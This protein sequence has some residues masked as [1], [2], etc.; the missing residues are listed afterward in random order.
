MFYCK[1]QYNYVPDNTHVG[2]A[3]GWYA[4]FVHRQRVA[5][6]VNRGERISCMPVSSVNV[7]HFESQ[8]RRHQTCEIG[9]SVAPKMDMCPRKILFI[10]FPNNF[11]I[12][13]PANFEIFYFRPNPR[14]SPTRTL[15]EMPKKGPVKQEE[16]ATDLEEAWPQNRM[17]D[18]KSGSSKAKSEL[19]P[20]EK[21]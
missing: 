12:Y 21:L 11:I 2:K 6:D 18:T 3:T 13:T 1:V 15:K 4:G 14:K 7:A 5:P 16:K 8:R 17:D 10:K 19:F 9:V 20:F